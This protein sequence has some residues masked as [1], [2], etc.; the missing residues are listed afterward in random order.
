MNFLK[1]NKFKI[2]V[3][4]VVSYFINK[5]REKGSLAESEVSQSVQTI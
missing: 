3:L 5:Q 2:I 4:I 1:K